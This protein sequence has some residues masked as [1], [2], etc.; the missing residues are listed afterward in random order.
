MRTFAPFAATFPFALGSAA[1]AMP[2]P[3]IGAGP[4]TVVLSIV[5]DEM[6]FAT[7]TVGGQWK[8]E[9]VEAGLV[10][11]VDLPVATFTGLYPGTYTGRGTRYNDTETVALGPPI[12]ITLVLPQPDAPD[13]GVFKHTIITD[14]YNARGQV[15]FLM[16]A[17]VPVSL[18]S[19]FAH[20]GARSEW[21]FATTP[22][23]DA[24]AAGEVAELGGSIS[25]GTLSDAEVRAE[26][27]ARW[28]KYNQTIQDA[29]ALNQENTFSVGAGIWLRL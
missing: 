22:E 28:V 6:E 23:N 20:P 17:Q 19:Q 2:P 24:I 18:Q 29:E 21:A 8:I 9:I 27:D 26:L 3:A 5:P 13:P 10:A 4:F 12:F 7:G 11:W 25:R 15:R 1:A 14:Y 16:W